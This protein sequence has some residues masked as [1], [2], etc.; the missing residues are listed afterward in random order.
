MPGKQIQQIIDLD[1]LPEGEQESVE[2]YIRG[3]LQAR[4]YR[5]SLSLAALEQI[6]AEPTVP[7]RKPPFRGDGELRAY[8]YSG[9]ILLLLVSDE[10][11]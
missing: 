5:S 6:V 10:Q 9:E 2:A 4:L 3:C 8:R 7:Y 1:C 11:Q